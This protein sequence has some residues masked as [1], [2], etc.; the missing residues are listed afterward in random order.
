MSV[1]SP[2][3][4]R[5]DP[6]QTAVDHAISSVSEDVGGPKYERLSEDSRSS[7]LSDIEAGKEGDHPTQ[8]S[9]GEFSDGNDTEAETERLEESPEKA[10]QQQ[11]LVLTTSVS[12]PSVS[13][14]N[15]EIAGQI[16]SG[17]A[18]CMSHNKCISKLEA[19]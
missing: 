10:R 16:S 9:I 8:A 12:Y 7:S 5:A 15:G 13:V 2:L 3:V 4:Q 11:N 14:V 19:Y 6:S 1:S 17:R 18:A